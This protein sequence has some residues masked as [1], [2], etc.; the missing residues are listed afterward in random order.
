M[1]KKDIITSIVIGLFTAFVWMTVFIRFEGLMS[2]YAWLLFPAFPIIFIFG[3]YLGKWLSVWKPF[4]NQ[5]SRFVMVGL[6]N[7]GI[8]FAIFNFLIHYTDI[9]RGGEISLFKSAAFVAA[10]INSYFWNKY[11]VFSAGDTQNK[12]KEFTSYL[13]VTLVGFG[14]NVGITSVI[15]NAIAP[16]FGV[17]QIGWDNLAAAMATLANLVWNFSGYRLIVFA[18]N[19]T[20]VNV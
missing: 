7:T 19:K 5:F 13:L 15:A 12:G 4:F 10:F 18:K 20:Q 2:T 17:T 9:D 3:L 16:Q 6:L 8:D 14:L 1:Y 11:W